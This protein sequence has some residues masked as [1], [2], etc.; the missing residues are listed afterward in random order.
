MLSPTD[1]QNEHLYRPVGSLMILRH[2]MEMIMRVR[3]VM[4]FARLFGVP[5]DVRQAFFVNGIKTNKS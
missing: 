4:L 1:L 3:I 5:I 2:L